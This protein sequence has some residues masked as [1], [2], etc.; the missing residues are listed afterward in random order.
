VQQGC[1]GAP[2]VLVHL[3]GNPGRVVA[4]VPPAWHWSPLQQFWSRAPHLPQKLPVALSMH[5]F[6]PLQLSFW[7]PLPWQQA[8]FSPPQATQLPWVQRAPFPLQKSLLPQ[9]GW[10]TAPQGTPA[11]LTHE[12]LVQAPAV[13]SARHICPGATQTLP[14]P[15]L[16]AGTQHPPALQALP[17]QQVS[18]GPPQLPVGSG[19]PPAP[20]LPPLPPPPAPPPLPPLTPMLVLLW[21]AL[22]STPARPRIRNGYN[23]TDFVLIDKGPPGKGAQ[24]RDGAAGR[25]AGPVRGF[26]RFRSLRLRLSRPTQDVATGSIRDGVGYAANR[27]DP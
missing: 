5:P 3:S 2:Q 14:S 24:G 7:S 16:A 9:Q 12:P 13:P 4:Q 23:R 6:V 8:C 19:A 11:A 27:E 21:Q 18:P 10:P 1:P 25:H 22:A 26:G 17:G 15:L 20:P